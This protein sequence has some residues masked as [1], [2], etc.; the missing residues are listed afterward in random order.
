MANRIVEMIVR[1]VADAKD[2]TNKVE[3]AEAKL[4]KM[5]DGAFAA[6]RTF[7]VA[8]AAMAA[9][10]VVP[11][12]AAI[13][14][15]SALADV[16]KT[17][18]MTAEETKALGK[19]LQAMSMDM[20]QAGAVSKA[21]LAK[22][23]AAAGQLG[24]KGAKNIAEFSKVVGQ[25]TVTTELAGDEAARAIAS[26]ANITGQATDQMGEFGRKYGSVLNELSNNMNTT[27]RRIIDM[28]LRLQGAGKTIGLTVQETTALSAA[29]TSMGIEAEMGGT[30]MQRTM[31]EMAK[32]VSL[33]TQ[34]M[35]RGF[36]VAGRDIRKF[37][38]MDVAGA[39]K[40]LGAELQDMLMRADKA[41][42][43]LARIAGVTFADFKERIAVNSEEAAKL[44]IENLKKID[45]EKVK[46]EQF[47]A[48]AGVSAEKFAQAF[49]E[50]PMEAIMMFVQGMARIQ[51]EG[52]GVFET[53]EKLGFESMRQVDAL[54]RLAGAADSVGTAVD[55]ANKAFKE[56]TSL[57]NESSIR[58]E[59]MA[60]K[61]QLINNQLGVLLE[62]IGE[63]GS[64]ENR[65]LLQEIS[66][67]LDKA[68]SFVDR[69]PEMVLA[70]LKIVAALTAILAA[71]AAINF[72][73]GT[74]GRTGQ[75]IMVLVKFFPIITGW[76]VAT[77]NWLGAIASG[78]SAATAAGVAAA[79]TLAA[80]VGGL[81][82]YLLGQLDF[83]EN[84]FTQ[85]WKLIVHEYRR[86]FDPDD[87][88]FMGYV[89]A[90][91]AVVV[92]LVRAAFDTI[93]GFFTGLIADIKGAF[94]ALIEFDLPKY[95]DR[96]I[97]VINRIPT[98]D[99][100]IPDSWLGGG[101]AT[102]QSVMG[103]GNRGIGGNVV[104]VNLNGVVIGSERDVKRLANMLA[105]YMLAAK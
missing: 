52:G 64:D 70:A 36:M 72:A 88:I 40:I 76:L 80:A 47:A 71:L 62:R 74:I 42:P 81:I 63:I 49:R 66:A 100:L 93:K 50:R 69:N 25:M 95:L 5:A 21:E 96:I 45:D 91:I 12:R 16:R 4:K 105:G 27:E 8:G 46:L 17:T 61:L 59:T 9:M 97:G 99:P 56:G 24:I 78:V 67:F 79:V 48:V 90:L 19:D 60:S 92:T 18:G 102:E 65:A 32:A 82:G 33:G 30:A 1:I 58:S 104:T 41:L 39:K 20:G 23:A 53:F 29:M 13:A 31:I 55:M 34:G 103:S 101:G 94:E 22:I 68:I 87:S 35:S 44:L 57:Q 89:K 86:W 51:K 43:E 73:V 2:F 75:Y 85:Y 11:A 38:M 54:T 28:D 7:A 3:N 14:W 15:E 6:S 37:A 98:I 26:I 10:L 77:L 84:Y 83:I